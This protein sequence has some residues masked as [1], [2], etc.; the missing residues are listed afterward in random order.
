[1]IFIQAPLTIFLLVHYTLKNVTTA[2]LKKSKKKEI[3]NV[4]EINVNTAIIPTHR[5]LQH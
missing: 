1:M 3:N 4:Q 5:A 2:L